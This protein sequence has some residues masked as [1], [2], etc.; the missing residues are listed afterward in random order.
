VADGSQR[1]DRPALNT[2]AAVEKTILRAIKRYPE[3]VFAEHRDWAWWR[4]RQIAAKG[5]SERNRLRALEAIVSR[6]DPEPKVSDI[7]VHAVV[8]VQIGFEQPTSG[9]D[10][11][12]Q[13][14]AGSL[15]IRVARNGHDGSESQ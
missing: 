11:Q 12:A 6:T 8:G 9:P 1:G 5:Q 7:S 13:L 3:F 14:P 15:E 4:M 2:E 10:P